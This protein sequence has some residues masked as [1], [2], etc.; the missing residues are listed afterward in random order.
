M[1]D[2]ERQSEVFRALG[3]PARLRILMLLPRRD[4]DVPVSVQDLADA[5]GMA[6]PNVSQHLRVLKAAGLVTCQKS[7]GCSYY[8]AELAAAERAISH[9]VAGQVAPG[10]APPESA[11]VDLE[12][13]S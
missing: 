10:L 12:S 6:Q 2:L 8:R 4:G 9:L 5:L 11:P 13:E 7:C 3:D 1:Y